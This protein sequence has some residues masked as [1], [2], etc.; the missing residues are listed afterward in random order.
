LSTL[1][2][3]L[4]VLLTIASIFLC[5]IVVTY[6]ANADN[7]RAKYTSLKSDRDALDKNVQ[8]LKTQVNDKIK[9]KDD[10]EKRLNS[11]MASLKA[12]ADELQAKLDN[13]EREKSKLLE[14]VNSWTAITE[15][16]Y[17]TNDKQGELLRGTQEELKK[18]QAEQIELSRKLDETTAAL[19]E[20][21]AIVDTLETEKK[22]LIEEKA[23]IQNKLDQLLQIGGRPAAAV[24]APV[25]QEKAVAKPAQPVVPA[26]ALKGRITSIDLKNSWA[27]ISIGS[28][29][30][31][32]EGMRFHA[33]RGDQF[34]C[35]ILIIDVDTDK[36]V[37]VLELVQQQPKTGDGVSTSL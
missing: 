23:A 5:G 35:D 21:N 15:N 6:V 29:D 20:K 9:E 13:A 26:T 25:T 7:Y 32:K 31:V 33:T 17:K 19:V 24:A 36:A 8:S 14:Q 4:I 1:T 11:E 10:L 28:A 37:G 3:I 34:I 30:G 22:R 16:F 2:K 12:K 27:S 18:A